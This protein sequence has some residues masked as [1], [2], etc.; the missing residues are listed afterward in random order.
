MSVV[1]APQYTQRIGRWT[2]W[3]T[4][5]M[6][7]GC[8]RHQY[9]GDETTYTIWCYD[10]PEAHITTIWKGEVPY[11]V[12]EGGYTQEQNDEDKTDFETNYK[13]TANLR[14]SPA[15]QDDC[16]QQVAVVG[17]QGNETNWASHKFTDA[18]SWYGT[19]IRVTE[20]TLTDSGDGLTFESG[21]SPWVDMTHGK[22]WD[23][24]SLCEDVP[25]GYAVT[26]TVDAVEKTP[27]KPFAPSGGDYTVDYTTGK[28]T[29]AASQAGKTVKA[30]YSYVVDS[31]WVLKPYVGYALDVEQAEL[32]FSQDMVMKG[33]IVMAYFGS[34]DHFAPGYF[35][36][37]T[38]IE[39][40][41]QTYNKVHQLIDEAIGSF[42]VI[43]APVGGTSRGMQSPV[44]GFPFKY[45]AVR[46]L[47][48]KWGMEVR[49]WVE[50]YDGNKNVPFEGEHATGTFYCVSR[51]EAIL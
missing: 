44:Y 13:A 9:E 20:E 16:S 11:T 43:G 30:S 28:V 24:E 27:R 38:I 2:A 5:H 4:H 46:R 23:E 39:L 31:I 18:T 6:A 22:V 45:G 32:Q 37:G 40:G 26:V 17:R 42:P 48:S 47:W 35:P 51:D 7:R 15:F 34:A 14:L 49:I 19:S 10:G 12:I 50:D 33:A 1:I 41:R 8:P 21:H 36:P 29:F 3:K 25:H